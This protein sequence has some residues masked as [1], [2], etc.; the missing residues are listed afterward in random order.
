M[1]AVQR[2]LVS[3]SGQMS[4]PASARRRWDLG[5]GGPVDVLDLGFGVL[6]LP[7][8][9]SADLLD[10]LLTREDHLAFVAALDDP[11]LETT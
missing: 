3:S 2:Y 5:E 1:A 10:S 9:G 4:L 8:G 7:A 6:T 11:D